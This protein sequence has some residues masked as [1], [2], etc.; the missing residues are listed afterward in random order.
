[1]AAAAVPAPL[2]APF[3]LVA[4]PLG[5]QLPRTFGN[6]ELLQ[7][8][9]L[10]SGSFGFVFVCRR[11]SDGHRFAAKAIDMRYWGLGRL[12]QK[13]QRLQTLVQREADILTGL[14]QHNHIVS[15]IDVA[16]EGLWLFFVFEKLQGNLLDEWCK[17]FR[18]LRPVEACYILRQ[19]ID[20]LQFLHSESIIHRD[21]K[22]E[23][24][25]VVRSWNS[26]DDVFIDVKIADFGL[27]KIV[28]GTLLNTHS[29]CGARRYKA[30]EVTQFGH[31]YDF[32]ADIWSLGV[33]FYVLLNGSFPQ[34]RGDRGFD[35][36]VSE[37]PAESRNIA[38]MM[39]QERPADRG[40]LESLHDALQRSGQLVHQASSAPAWKPRFRIRRKRSALEVRDAE[41]A[42][43]EQDVEVAQSVQAKARR[44]EA[45]ERDVVLALHLT[46][47]ENR[48]GA[49]QR[50]AA[51]GT[52]ADAEFAL[53]L[54]LQESQQAAGERGCGGGGGSGGMGGGDFFLR[55][56]RGFGGASRGSTRRLQ[57]TARAQWRSR[58]PP[59]RRSSAS[60]ASAGMQAAAVRMGFE[61]EV[62]QA[63]SLMVGVE[64]GFV[65]AS[66]TLGGIQ[67]WL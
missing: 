14:R 35:A 39:L 34:R 30:P 7:E 6:F 61:E 64:T 16:I 65:V 23:N 38:S 62:L 53:R 11:R 32:R 50:N 56:L 33:L 1:M 15:F 37:L 19:L 29:N 25:L 54:Q 52:D 24:V 47:E 63:S 42:R 4:R 46:T 48:K 58:T 57:R 22:L 28:E 45:E 2:P 31:P 9:R 26:G 8:E 59:S 60:L 3:P 41:V 51:E 43:R 13:Q 36:D 55:E 66:S 5:A 40:S 49:E 67:R 21:L 20:G 27:S 44:L 12:D 17:L 10:G 18:P